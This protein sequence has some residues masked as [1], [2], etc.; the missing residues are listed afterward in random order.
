MYMSL[1]HLAPLRT[2]LRIEMPGGPVVVAP[3][4]SWQGILKLTNTTP[5]ALTVQLD[6]EG[7]EGLSATFEPA[8]LT[9]AS[10][11]SV[12]VALEISADA[13]IVGERE[14][15]LRM[16]SGEQAQERTL[17]VRIVPEMVRLELGADE[18]TLVAPFALGKDGGRTF[19]HVPPE[20]RA[21][22]GPWQAEDE[23]G[24]ATW[25]VNLPI[26]AEYVL[27]AECLWRDTKGNSFYAQVDDGEP[28]MIGNNENFGHWQWV[29]G[30][31]TAL[32]AGEHAV[33][34]L[35]REDGARVAQVMLTNTGS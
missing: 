26:A 25:R 6:S 21:S 14:L 3:G 24:S 34:L 13:G 20:V 32:D 19:A 11:E 22:D 8:K 1:G 33:T 17:P 10:G 31:T 12:E 23:T 2:P 35:G 4:T 16:T 29:K 5:D 18:A 7:A 30:P 15:T 9:V 28:T 27:M